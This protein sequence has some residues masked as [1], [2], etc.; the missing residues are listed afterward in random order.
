ML[1]DPESMEKR[2]S[3]ESLN[4][5]VVKYESGPDGGEEVSMSVEWNG[6]STSA[7]AHSGTAGRPT[8]LAGCPVS[9]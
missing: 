5:D 9:R 6:V 8:A 2:R 3:R 7:E 1:N 4:V